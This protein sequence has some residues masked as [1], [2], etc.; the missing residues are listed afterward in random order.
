MTPEQEAE[1]ILRVTRGGCAPYTGSANLD[2]EDRPNG[3]G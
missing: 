3:D 2:P 1:A